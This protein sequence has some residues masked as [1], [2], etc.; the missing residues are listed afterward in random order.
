MGTP[1]TFSEVL[2]NCVIHPI[3][4]AWCLGRAVQRGQIAKI[5]PVKSM[6]ESVR[7]KVIIKGKV[8]NIISYLLRLTVGSYVAK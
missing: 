3:S 4:T 1:I 8:C 7:G 2:N 6:F 5:D